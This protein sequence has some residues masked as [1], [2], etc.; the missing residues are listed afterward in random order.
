MRSAR[1]AAR[2]PLFARL[3]RAPPLAEARRRPRAARAARARDQVAHPASSPIASVMSAAS[4]GLLSRIQRRGVTPLVMLRNF[5]GHSVVEVAQ[6]VV[7]Q[8]LGVQRRDAVDARGCRRV[9]RCAIRTV[10]SP[11][12][13]DERQP[14]HERLV[15]RA[16]AAAHLVEEPAV[17]LEDDLEVPRQEVAQRAAAASAPAPRAAACGSC[18]RQCAARDRP[19]PCPS[20]GRARPRAAASAR[21][22]RSRDACR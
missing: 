13:V 8:Q 9:A 4:A 17:D 6:H 19:R 16:P 18:R 5:S 21:R 2:R 20:R 1:S 3:T 14:S 22:R 7:L 10:F 15:V 11:V 12:L